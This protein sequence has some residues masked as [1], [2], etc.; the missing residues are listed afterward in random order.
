MSKRT[1]ISL[2]PPPNWRSNNTQD[3]ELR[4]RFHATSTVDTLGS[5]YYKAPGQCSL[6]APYK[7]SNKNLSR[8]LSLHLEAIA[9]AVFFLETVINSYHP[10][11]LAEG[12]HLDRPVLGLGA[13]LGQPPQPQSVSW[14]G[15]YPSSFEVSRT[16]TCN[17]N[18]SKYQILSSPNPM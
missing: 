16:C 7:K 8:N 10:P 18:F 13:Q 12:R 17:K 4:P 11:R 14:G 15:S 5:I 6:F 2:Q 9:V 1:I 3:V